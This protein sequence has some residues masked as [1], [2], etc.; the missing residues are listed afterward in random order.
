MHDDTVAVGHDHARLVFDR[1][2]RTLDELE[3]TFAARLHMGAVLDVGGRPEAYS[4]RVVSRVEQ[5]VECLKD[6]SLV[7][8]FEL[9]S[10]IVLPSAISGCVNAS[11]AAHLTCAF[12]KLL[13]G[14]L[15]PGGAL[16]PP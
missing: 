4:G 15:L 8:L 16:P 9:R 5:G 2:G 14:P 3:D 11:A 12:Q 10:H 7:A 6:G 13:C 1:G